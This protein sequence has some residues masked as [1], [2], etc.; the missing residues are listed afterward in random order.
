MQ[1]YTYVIVY[2]F[3]FTVYTYK[4]IIRFSRFSEV[5]HIFHP[6]PQQQTW[7]NPKC[8]RPQFGHREHRHI[9][10]GHRVEG[11][12]CRIP[13]G[14]VQYI[15]LHSLNLTWHLKMMVSNRNLLFQ[16]SIFRFYVS[17]RGGYMNGWFL[18]DF[19]GSVNIPLVPWESVMGMLDPLLVS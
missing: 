5:F 19:H 10:L 6:R 11:L 12:M 17:F 1:K 16:G 14:L 4:N 9:H 8:K 7:F 3:I 15:Y 13:M 2:T 18:W